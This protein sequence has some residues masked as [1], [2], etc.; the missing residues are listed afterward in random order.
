MV[1][2]LAIVLAKMLLVM[3]LGFVLLA[4]VVVFVYYLDKITSRPAKA[5][6]RFL[7]NQTERLSK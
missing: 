6:W 3:V 2:E 7:R 4:L 1:L 5:L